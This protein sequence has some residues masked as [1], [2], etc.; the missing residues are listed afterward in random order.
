MYHWL[1]TFFFLEPIVRAYVAYLY[2]MLV[3][4]D[5]TY[6]HKLVCRIF[7]FSAEPIAQFRYLSLRILILFLTLCFH[8]RILLPYEIIRGLQ[9]VADFSV[10]FPYCLDFAQ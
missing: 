8:G 4:R 5:K 9:L 6:I 3:G 2:F 7:L 1:F 10:L